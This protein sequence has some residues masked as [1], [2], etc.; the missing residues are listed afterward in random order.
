M[1][2]S[3]TK[4]R[5]AWR[6]RRFSR[7]SVSRGMRWKCGRFPFG[8]CSAEPGDGSLP[9]VRKEFVEVVIALCGRGLLDAL[10]FEQSGNGLGGLLRSWNHV[11][12]TSG[13]PL[14]AWP[15][16]RRMRRCRSLFSPG[17]ERRCERKRP[18]SSS[19]AGR[20]RGQDALGGRPECRSERVEGVQASRHALTVSGIPLEVDAEG[21]G[22]RSVVGLIREPDVGNASVAFERRR[23]KTRARTA[24][25]HR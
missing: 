16:R 12:M 5:S 24:H 7:R 18:A 2:G 10:R 11:R 3:S 25:E 19:G 13:P 6:R 17:L 15:C 4:R 23:I 21:P 14:R 9:E 8:T 1:Q 20:G 22:T